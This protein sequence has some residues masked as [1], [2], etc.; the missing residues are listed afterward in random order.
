M[1]VK[2]KDSAVQ[3]TSLMISLGLIYEPFEERS[4]G[5]KTF[6]MP[7]YSHHRFEVAALYGLYDAILGT[8]SGNEEFAGVAH[9]LMMKRVNGYAVILIQTMQDTVWG[10]VNGMGLC[11]PWCLLAMLDRLRDIPLVA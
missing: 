4:P 11:F 8:G 7:L 5:C 2:S 3:D 9:G 10:Y 1:C 6:G